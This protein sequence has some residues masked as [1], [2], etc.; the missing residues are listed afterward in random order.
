MDNT[1]KALLAK[2]WKDEPLELATG[3]HYFDDT[4]TVRVSGTVEKQADQLV[5]PTTSIPRASAHSG[6]DRLA[7]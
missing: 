1:V 3:R 5:A 6:Q 2:A 4:L 7:R